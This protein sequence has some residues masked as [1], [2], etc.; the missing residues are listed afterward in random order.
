MKIL[1]RFAL[2]VI[3]LVYSAAAF[4]RDYIITEFGAQSGKMSTEAI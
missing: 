3:L 1:R 2:P 4:S